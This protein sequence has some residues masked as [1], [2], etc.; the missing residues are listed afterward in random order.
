M[1]HKVPG[2]ILGVITFAIFFLGI[3]N[4]LA[5]VTVTAAT[6][7]AAISADTNTAN[8]TTTWTTLTGPTIAEGAH[9]DFPGS[10]TFILNAPS[11][12]SFSTTTVVSSTITV[13]AG[14]SSCFS[15]T[16]TTATPATSTITFT[17]NAQDGNGGGGT[18][19][20][21][22]V[23]SHIQVRP[24][25]GTPLAS[26]NITKS[27]TA[28]V[29][30]ITN[31][32]TNIGT[33]TE[34]AGAKNQLVY[35]TQ[36][37][38]T[39]TTSVAFTTDPIIKLED[40]YGNTETSDN[41][42]TVTLAPVL[43]TQSCGGTAGSGTL[44]S[45]PASVAAVTAGV[46]TYTAMQYSFGESI[47]IC[48]TSSGVTSVLSNTVAVSNPVPTTTNISP[49][50]TVAGG[51][52]FTLTVTGTNFVSNSSVQI[53]GASRTTTFASSSQLT[54]TILA[55]DIAV[56]A[57]SS[58]TVVNPAQGGGTSN[59]QTL[60]INNPA[61]TLTS[62]SPTSTTASSTSFTLTL[63][64]TNFNASSSV[65]WNS[66]VR[67]T[68]FVSSTTLQA[69]ILT[70]DLAAPTTSAVTVV[71]PTP[72]GGTSAA[73]TFTVTQIPTATTVN[74]SATSSIYGSSVTF[75]ATVTPS[76]G[77]PPSGTVTFKDGATT[78]GMG[79]LNGANPG[80][81]TFSTSTL[82]VAGSPHSITAVYGGDSNFFGST[83]ASISQIITTKTLTV[84]G[85]TA[86][87]KVYD[88]STT[89]TL[90]G[91]PGTLVG[92]IGSDAV[93]L[94]GTAI[95]TFATSSVG[96]GI[97]VQV[98]GQS[99][100][101]AQSSDYSLTE[102]STSANITAKNLT[103]T[104]ITANDKTYDGNTAA[105]LNTVSAVLVGVVGGDAVTLNTVGATGNFATSSV[106]TGILVTISGLTISGSSSN[107]YSLTQPT[108][109]A[110]ITNPVPTT[111]SISPT[112]TIEGNPQ[113]TLTVNGTN[114]VA[115][116]AVNFNNAARAT[117]FVSSSTLTAT[118]LASD[119]TTVGTY[120]VTVTNPIPGGGTSNSQTFTILSSAPVLS[121]ISPTSTTAGGA[122]FTLTLNGS[123]FFASSTA[124]WN[125]ASLATT[126]ISSTTLTAT[127]PATDIATAGTASVTVVTP[128]PGGGTSGSQTFTILNPVPATTSISP[129]STTAGNPDFTLA[130][131]GTN[132]V[133]GS[134]VNFNGSAKS[135]AFVS[136]TTV[137]ATV[138]A[139][140]VATA[141]SYPVTVTN[142]TPGGGTSNSQTFTV[143]VVQNPIPTLSAI[144][145]T[146]T[147]A[148]SAGFTLTL[149]GT[150]FISSS[151][152]QWNGSPRVTTYVSSTTITATV[153][154]SDVAIAG[155]ASVTVVTPAPGGGTSNSQTFTILNPVPATASLS[156]TSTAAGS[157]GFTLTV[158]GTNFVASSVVDWNGSSRTTSFVSST[159][160]TA[161]ILAADVAATGTASISV[162]NA[163]PGG[164]TS[165]AQTFTVTA[166]PN[167]V[168]TTTSISPVSAIAGT[169]GF[170]LTVNGTNFVASSAVDWNGS[171][172][173]TTIVS[174]TQAT[175][176]ITA[177]DI[178]TA[179]TASVTVVSPAPGGGTSNAQ[180]FTV[181][182]AP[183]GAIKFVF[184]NVSSSAVVGN[185]VMFN[186]FAEIAS[187]TVDTAFEQG[188]T[189]AVSG[190]GAGGGLVTIV[191]GVGT[192]TVSDHVA[193][194]VTLSLQDSQS[195]SLNVS[196][197]ANVTFTPGTVAQ[198][199]LNHPGD[200]NE[201]SRLGYAVS[202]EDQFGN[203]VS[204][205]GTT[206]YLYTNSASA[207]A[208][209][210]NAASGGAQ[211]TSVTIPNGSTSTVF[212]YYDDTLGS[213]TVTA[214]DNPVAPDGA[215]GI[216]DAS[217]TFSVAPGAVKFIFANV[218]AS[219]TVGT[220]ATVSVE[221]VD[222]SNT[223]YPSYNGGV[224]V[225]TSGSATG[226]GLVNLVNGVG[227]ATVNDLTAETVTIGFLDTQ[228][229]GLGVTAT[230]QVIFNAAPVAT[231]APTAG[232]PVGTQVTYGIKPGVTITFAGMAYP[233]ATVTVISKAQG[234]LA[235]PVTQAVPVSADGSFLVELDN[236]T[237]LTGQTYLLSFVDR[238][239]LIAQ[240]KAYNIPMQDKLVYGNILA[241]PTLG[242]LNSSVVS[243]GKPLAITGYATPKATVE[244]FIDGD[245]AGTI[246]VNDPSGRYSYSLDTDTLG[247][248]R[249]AVW[250]I[251]KVAQSATEV[252]GY[253][254]SLSQDEIFVDAATNGA[255]I[256][257]STSTGLYAFI[258][259]VT[260]GTGGGVLPVVVGQMYIKQAESDFSNQESFTVSPLA[261]PK[262]DLNGDGVVDIRDLSVFLAYVK[263]LSADLAN[264]H[265][266]NPNIVKTLD[267]N[268]DGVV[269]TKDLS[270]LGAAILHP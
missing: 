21:Q 135:T 261:N 209:F 110:S 38:S 230:A 186:I 93:S 215:A 168:P 232:G 74:S 7:G 252:S 23:F 219:E 236:V 225:T 255:L 132:F 270:I 37:A 240:T 191:N 42:S 117:I 116:S 87:N 234:L 250:A 144:S 210:F 62:L 60:T 54:A 79:T 175:A 25:A 4:A 16:S 160:I 247:V 105:T 129:T 166:A 55:S 207:N 192:T 145:P 91:T 133:A 45:T 6:G 143:L 139:S 72:G 97:T 253:T 157:S 18:T 75:T 68:T 259:A 80:V 179:G 243:K 107:N 29:S 24:T 231:P 14:S 77:G 102:P 19:R 41:A 176:L 214:S 154:A 205:S 15:F 30:G 120:P 142:G 69:T 140:D 212:W 258:P 198:F 182:P 169:S 266:T 199:A 121:S 44:A 53:N 213:R 161:T 235:V 262:L 28:T 206:A 57:T 269:D 227:T 109:T 183:A 184:G 242:F 34:V 138:L 158:N 131:N 221:A 233:G 66:L 114:F 150:G 11:G 164:G 8:G 115:S 32:T 63:T 27:G 165:N 203:F 5:A 223:I 127:V 83:S 228:S 9:R 256:T 178:A 90:L 200:M 48:A 136:S 202:R 111:T 181:N 88:A 128:A 177:A 49:T 249:H 188:V 268:G 99:L 112:S 204:A 264:F 46:M 241:A 65:R 92:V 162:V 163:A 58:I 217:D 251:Q 149:T 185:N 267:L 146:S 197:T 3:Q 86:Q 10:G 2:Q 193:Q 126:Y 151:T 174:S 89:A 245:P 222:S 260:G 229:T 211:V 67:A 73:Q 244:L 82:S 78:I 113:F 137:T 254:N 81:A 17:L 265:L 155:T 26:G 119:I 130:V 31:G 195:T 171:S 36:P 12:F 173:T 22:V 159:Q 201:G 33:L 216:S 187:N 239:G 96:T 172:R 124:D 141:G 194:T 76:A 134:V 61:P 226:G 35:T 125:G 64:G 167:P 257:K 100:T 238:N 84:T 118:I 190:A 51:A 39:A 47:K 52:N 248:G 40:K 94:T 70:S 237:R 108:T 208:A 95:G 59:A 98:S 180:T 196:D 56:G 106:G 122:Q 71:N 103:V 152:A 123:N 224:T 218:P 263:N 220:G 147:V 246:V 85:I 13:I 50:S 1:K 156:P 170:T 20:C 101:G 104:G 189:L 43:S 153:L 148:G